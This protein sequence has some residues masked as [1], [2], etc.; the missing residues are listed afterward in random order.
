MIYL[1]VVIEY[2]DAISTLCKYH[3]KQISVLSFEINESNMMKLMIPEE[4]LMG[5]Y[6][7]YLFIINK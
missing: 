5:V 6:C 3:R 4:E 2:K 7:I 1:V